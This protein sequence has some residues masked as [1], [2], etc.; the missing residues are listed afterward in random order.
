MDPDMCFRKLLFALRDVVAKHA[1]CTRTDAVNALH[2]LA[3]WLDNGGF[4]PDIWVEINYVKN[5]T[6][7]QF[8]NFKEETP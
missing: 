1:D 2:I 6:K 4:G 7:E 3:D 8:P 5:R